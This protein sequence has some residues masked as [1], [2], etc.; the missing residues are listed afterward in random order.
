MARDKSARAGPHQDHPFRF[1]DAERLAHRR[2][3]HLEHVT[4]FG[5]GRQLGPRLKIALDAPR[6]EILRRFGKRRRLVIQ[7]E[8]GVRDLHLPCGQVVHEEENELWVE[9]DRDQT[10]AF[11]LIASL[12]RDKGI[13][14]VAI[15]EENIESIVARIYQNGVAG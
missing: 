3:A 9:F 7:F 6:E 8:N 15:K 4:Q 13:T 12:E 2:P 1:Q 11:D 5:L 10:S 14:D